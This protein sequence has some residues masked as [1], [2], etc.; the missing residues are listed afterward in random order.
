[1]PLD[2][3]WD[4]PYAIA[5]AAYVE[6]Y[7]FNVLEG[8]D[9]MVHRHRR[10]PDSSDVRQN[11]QTDM[12]PVCQ[13]S[14]SCATRDEWDMLDDYSLTEDFAANSPNMDEFYRRVVSSDEEDCGDSDDGSVAD[15][16]RD[17]WADACS[18]AFQNAVGAFPPEAD[19][20]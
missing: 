6:D 7:N 12:T 14:M 16:E 18:F 15:L 2:S 13:L 8:M 9:L 3:D 17:T 10:D 11:W 20:I 19:D 1:M 5:S 4:D